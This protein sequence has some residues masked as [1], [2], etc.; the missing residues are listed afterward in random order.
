MDNILY[1]SFFLVVDILYILTLCIY[2]YN[3]QYFRT[4]GTELATL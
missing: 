2:I 3:Y 1:A 4:L